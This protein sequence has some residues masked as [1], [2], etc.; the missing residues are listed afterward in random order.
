[1][2]SCVLTIALPLFALQGLQTVSAQT[3]L[4]SLR[5]P[6]RQAYVRYPISGV[7]T[8]APPQS[9]FL[10]GEN[11]SW[12][13]DDINAFLRGAGLPELPVRTLTPADSLERG[14]FLSVANPI[15]NGMFEAML[16]QHVNVTPRY[17]GPEGYVLD[18]MP[19]RVI[20]SGSDTA[21]L[22]YGVAG[23]LRLLSCAHAGWLH[24]CR[25]VDAPEF[26]IRWFLYGINIQ[27]GSNIPAAKKVWERATR[28]RLNGVKLDDAKFSSLSRRPSFYFDSLRSLKKWADAH[29]LA[30]IPGIFPFG[31]SNALLF[32]DPNLASG[33]PVRNQRF[34]IVSDTA[35]LI[36]HRPVDYVNGGFETFAGNT[37]PGFLYIDQ[38]GKISFVDT[39]V[40]HGGRASVR[41]E[42]FSL[43]AAEYGHGRVVFK[44]PVQPFTLYHVRAWVRTENLQPA[45][46]IRST[47]IGNKGYSLTFNVLHVPSTTDWMRLDITF[48]SLEADTALLYWGTWGAKE[49]KI[50]WDDLSCEEVPLVNL[51]RREGAPLI[52]QHPVLPRVFIEGIDFDTLRD[53]LTGMVPYA[54][55][56]DTWHTPPTFRV[57]KTGG[58]SEGDTILVSYY[59]AVVINDDQVMITM[60]DPKVYEIAEREFA[61]LDSILSPRAYFFQHD[62]IRTMNWD[63]GDLARGLTPARIIADNVGRCIDIVRKRNENADLWVWSDMFDEYH[64]AVPGNYYLVNGDLRGSADLIPRSL[65]IVNWN[66]REGI[67]QNSLQFFSSKGFRQ[68]SAPYYDQDENNIRRWKEW[69]R[70]TPAFRGMMYTTW[71]AKYD[72][73]EAFGD[74]AWNH[75]PYIE[76]FPPWVL[77]SDGRLDLLIRITGDRW[78]TGWTAVS[79]QIH[80]RTSP[81]ES[82][83]PQSFTPTPGSEQTVTVRLAP[84]TPWLQWYITALDNRGWST[85]VPFGDTVYYELGALPSGKTDTPAPTGLVFYGAYPQPAV[86]DDH[87]MLDFMAPSGS[88]VELSIFDILGKVMHHSVHIATGALQETRIDC[89]RWPH[90]CYA[91]V[92]RDRHGS[93]CVTL[94]R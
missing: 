87:V 11:L 27:V 47:V 93:R 42:N 70:E 30:V 50:W 8:P 13:A 23:L 69:T 52:V 40:R 59:H 38:P 92:M 86:G 90:G 78:D 9:I 5:P 75:A 32:H 44:T 17:P 66:G 3:L 12:A 83:T 41:L 82:F 22:R 45:S 60:S 31:Y 2:R 53:P 49:G 57:R 74:Y 72:H 58:L 18:V 25:I 21:G 64:N 24:A 73:L 84:A 85:R 35:R 81:G 65:G 29:G 56:Y 55:A 91:A 6:P 62:E 43:Y 46:S 77:P 34:V 63:A 14:I 20:V 39:V 28:A 51:I 80:Y 1:M 15:V 26:P 68:I 19:S 71:Q 88:A 37:F 94:V 33:L 79:S 4:D 89:S 10:D 36:P 61:I 7:Y 67:V 54:G 16:D 76:H 48:N